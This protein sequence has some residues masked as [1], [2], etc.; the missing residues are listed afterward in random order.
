M[1]IVFMGT[2][3]FAV[4]SLEACLELG[5]VIAV[6][7]QPD[8][9]RGR[10][11]EVSFSPVKTLAVSKGI[12]VL[13]P[14]KIRG[15]NFA[16]EL[17]ALKA[18]IAVVTAYG[19]ILPQDVLDAPRRGCVNVH[20]SLLPRWRGAAPIQWAIAAGDEKTGV[21][22]MQM[23]A[24]MDTGA[25]IERLEIPILPT[26]TSATLHDRLAVLGG[27]ALKRSLKRYV[28][29][30]IGATPQPTDGVVMARM[31]EKEDGRLDWQKPAAELERR[32]RAFTPWPG[33]FCASPFGVLKVTKARAG[34]GK[35][36][37]GTVLQADANGIEVACAQGSLVLEMIQPEGKRAMTAKEFL[38]SRKLAVG[39]VMAVT[40]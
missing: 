11:Q 40:A 23:D 26:D 28:D 10:G 35:G 24:G 15:T 21:C 34:E 18:D 39:T 29:G 4:K 16:E 8:K 9:P 31:I 37:V 7:T 19:K 5:E 13:Q 3:D 38:A 33:A 12:T 14:Q 36:A 32:L 25:V 27:D 1:R 2:P 20:A 22:L 6:V 17:R 30:E